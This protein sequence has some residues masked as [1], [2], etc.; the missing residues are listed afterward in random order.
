MEQYNLAINHSVEKIQKWK[1]LIMDSPDFTATEL[2][3]LIYLLGKIENDI[4][5]L[6]QLKQ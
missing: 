4:K 3:A 5:K 1:D 2:R 6:K